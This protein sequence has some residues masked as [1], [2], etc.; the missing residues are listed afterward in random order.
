MFHEVRL[1]NLE[2]S[3]KIIVLSR[4]REVVK[5]KMGIFKLKKLSNDDTE[6]NP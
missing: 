5:Y 1:N 2:T 6:K 3:G 4:E